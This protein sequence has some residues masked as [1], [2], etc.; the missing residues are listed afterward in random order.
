MQCVWISLLQETKE[1]FERA[2]AI[3]NVFYLSFLIDVP[4]IFVISVTV[5]G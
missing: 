1:A 2:T 5:L 4:Y 3:I